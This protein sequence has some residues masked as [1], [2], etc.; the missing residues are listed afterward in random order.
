LVQTSVLIGFPDD[1]SA[2]SDL[3]DRGS[4]RT[5]PKSRSGGA[6]KMSGVVETAVLPQIPSRLL[7]GGEWREAASGR[8]FAT[9]NPATEE[10]LAEVS[11]AGPSDVDAAVSAAR[12]ALRRG[13]WPTMTGADRGRI[14]HRLAAILRERSEDRHGAAWAANPESAAISVAPHSTITQSRKQYGCRCAHDAPSHCA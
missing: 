9:L 10:V 7:I 6:S 4:R 3:I 2:H 11:E 13:A 1:Q 12:D 5:V 8:R 14:L